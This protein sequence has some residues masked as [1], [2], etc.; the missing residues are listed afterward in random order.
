MKN[1]KIK[2]EKLIGKTVK[3]ISDNDNYDNWRGK[4]LIIT[5]ASNSGKYYD[6]SFF[7]E[8]LCDFKTEDGKEFPFALYEYEFEIQ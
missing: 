3:I 4:K 7:P 2:A 5:Y 8:M 1:Y 6:E